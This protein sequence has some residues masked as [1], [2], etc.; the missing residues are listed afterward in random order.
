MIRT[1]DMRDIAPSNPAPP[2][3]LIFVVDVV[4]VVAAA[5]VFF[6]VGCGVSARTPF[7][8]RLC[9]HRQEVYLMCFTVGSSFKSV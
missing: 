5:T 4:V 7:S 6:F 2:H 3:L 8:M 1:G 9:D